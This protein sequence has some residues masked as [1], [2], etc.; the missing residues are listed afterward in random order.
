MR[1]P[2]M[3]SVTIGSAGQVNVAAQQANAVRAGGLPRSA[4]DSA[5]ALLGDEEGGCGE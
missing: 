5:V 1:E 4:S 2:T 3:P